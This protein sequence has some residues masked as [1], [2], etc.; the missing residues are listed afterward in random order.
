MMR[1]RARLL[2]VLPA[3]LFLHL[4][5]DAASAPAA[6]TKSKK[7]RAPKRA[8]PAVSASARAAAVRKVSDYLE[9]STPGAFAQ[10]GALVPVFEQLYRLA[11]GDVQAAPVH[12]LHYGDSHTAAD[13][14]TG[15]LRD[16]FKEKFGNGGSGFSLAGR[17]FAGY[18][19]FDARGGAT[20]LWHSEGFRS[21]TGDGYF[22]LGGFSITATRAL[23]SVYLDAEC[24]HLEVHYLRQPGGGSVALYDGA[25]LRDQFST[26]GELSPGFVRYDVPP[27][28]HRFQLRTTS[29]APVRLFGWVAD[30][31]RGVT[32]EAL[33][34]NGAEAGIILR[35]NAAMLAT[36]LQR[37]SPGLIVLAYGTNEASDPS[38]SPESYR[39]MFSSLLRRLR[40]IAPAASFLVIGPPDRWS[41][42]RGALRPHP[43]IDWIISAQQEACRENR[44]AFW[45]ARERMGGKGTMRDWVY[46]GLAQGDYVHLTAAGYRRLA[47]V[48]FQ[49]IIAQY[50]TYTQTAHGHAN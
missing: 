19:R 11:A 47:E 22:G 6:Q 13:E 12:I 3:L 10:P 23:Q 35:W 15:G 2:A 26:D 43:G 20:P 28:P 29:A 32:Y 7:Q 44:A 24:D 36:Y 4:A 9:A 18:R 8:A 37:R 41:R 46:A 30:R 48:L 21:A 49:D 34:I 5:S 39:E 45:D 16:L 33:G 14:W 40:E 17:P 42:S 38:W 31:D 50:D 27:G 25:E 1:H